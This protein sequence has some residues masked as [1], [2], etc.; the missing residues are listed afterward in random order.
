M[1]QVEM[2][3]NHLNNVIRVILRSE[4]E[5]VK[6]LRTATYLALIR[7]GVK[8]DMTK[9]VA[10]TPAGSDQCDFQSII[11]WLNKVQPGD[12]LAVAQVVQIDATAV[13]RTG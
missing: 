12:T 5:R 4:P 3:M 1:I 11:V 9:A 2:P 7:L 8:R 6:I 13:S 10:K